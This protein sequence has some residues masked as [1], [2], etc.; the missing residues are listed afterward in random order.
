MVKKKL[1]IFAILLFFVIFA[2]QSSQYP[3]GG[4]SEIKYGFFPFCI[5]IL[6]I[7]SCLA[8]LVVKND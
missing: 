3:F 8:A 2:Y 1:I 5:S 7:C 6:G 4:P